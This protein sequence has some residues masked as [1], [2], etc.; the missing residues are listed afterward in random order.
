MIIMIFMI[1]TIFM[2]LNWEDFIMKTFSINTA[3]TQAAFKQAGF[4]EIREIFTAANTIQLSSNFIRHKLMSD[5]AF[6]EGQ[7][8]GSLRRA[9]LKT[10]LF[11]VGNAEYMINIDF[12]NGIAPYINNSG[13][14]ADDASD[15]NISELDPDVRPEQM[16]FMGN[17]DMD[18]NTSEQRQERFKKLLE[19][20]LD[21][22]RATRMDFK[23]TL[24]KLVY[25]AGMA[26]NIIDYDLDDVLIYHGI[27]QNVQ[28]IA[29]FDWTADL[30]SLDDYVNAILDALDNFKEPSTVLLL[31][32]MLSEFY[33]H[34]A[35]DHS[36]ARLNSQD[37]RV[38]HTLMGVIDKLVNSIESYLHHHHVDASIA[39]IPDCM[40]EEAAAKYLDSIS[41]FN[42]DKDLDNDN[43]TLDHVSD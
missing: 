3:T 2:I 21:V 11:A 20:V 13:D 37:V 22:S 25:T 4:T 28:S 38:L 16:C 33:N 10:L 34:F 19:G 36:I 24:S 43:N 12:P 27:L 29:D 39:R 6:T 31:N 41:V 17:L 7:A 23:M 42:V 8:A 5:Y 15:A 35:E 30:A 40:S 1:F 18:P 26:F 9:C 14:P 32:N